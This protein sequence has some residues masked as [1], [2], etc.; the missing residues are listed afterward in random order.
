MHALLVYFRRK[1]RLCDNIGVR[2]QGMGW[3]RSAQLCQCT[4]IDACLWYTLY[5]RLHTYPK[6]SGMCQKSDI[7]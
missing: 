4:D 2:L 7:Q 6:T 3:K 5:A 1:D